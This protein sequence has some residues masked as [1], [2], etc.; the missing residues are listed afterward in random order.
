LFVWFFSIVG[1]PPGD[2]TN[3]GCRCPPL[4]ARSIRSFF[5]QVLSGIIF[6]FQ[7][8]IFAVVLFEWWH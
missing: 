6:C 1:Y 2:N 8:L 7:N 3:L 5:I 4:E